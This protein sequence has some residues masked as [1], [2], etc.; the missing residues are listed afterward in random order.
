MKKQLWMRVGARVLAAGRPGQI[1][2]IW[3]HTDKGGVFVDYI[4]VRL[5]GQ[6]EADAYRP[7]ALQLDRIQREVCHA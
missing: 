1:A 3:S 5:D 2:A 4:D 6:T 7:Q